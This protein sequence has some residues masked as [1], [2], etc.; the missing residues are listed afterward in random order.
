MRWTA[1]K[2]SQEETCRRSIRNYMQGDRE[3]DDVREIDSWQARESPAIG[4]SRFL[5]STVHQ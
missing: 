1:E 3:G 4:V 5:V 2:A